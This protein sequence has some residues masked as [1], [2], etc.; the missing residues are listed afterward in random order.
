MYGSLIHI[1]TIGFQENKVFFS[2][3][4]IFFSTSV[5]MIE[6]RMWRLERLGVNVPQDC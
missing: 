5:E 2:Y 1:G 6:N 4:L 3:I